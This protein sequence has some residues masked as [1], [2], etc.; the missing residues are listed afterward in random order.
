MR[1]ILSEI[2]PLL[3]GIVFVFGGLSGQLVLRGTNSST[4]LAV[5]GA[6]ICV[7]GIIRLATLKSR[8]QKEKELEARTEE[9]IEKFKHS[10]IDSPSDLPAPR[11]IIIKRPNNFRA[12]D[13]YDIQLNGK[14]IGESRNGECF[15]FTTN[16][17]KNV[18]STVDSK[19]P[20]RKMAPLFFEVVSE[21]IND[22]KEEIY[23]N[24][25]GDNIVFAV[26]GGKENGLKQI[27]PAAGDISTQ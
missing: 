6:G 8:M 3:L 17:T 24:P 23:F 22:D 11:N 1:R 4:L 16:K 27:F 15:K 14:S 20:N 2:Y 21:N 18:I 9:Q 10:I 13:P 7:Y 12:S 19:K 26:I 5:V 25:F